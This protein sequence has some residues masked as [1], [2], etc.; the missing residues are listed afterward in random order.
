MKEL[1]AL[2]LVV[3]CGRI[4]F[5]DTDSDD[6]MSSGTANLAFVT[7]LTYPATLGG[8]AGADTMC[9]QR[10]AAAGLPGQ[11]VAWLSTS[12][13]HA[14]SRLAGSRGWRLVDGTA[15][16]DH[17]SDFATNATLA[18]LAL[19]ELGNDVRAT[20]VSVW[21]GTSTG[22]FSGQAC[23]DWTVNLAS[24]NAHV[25]TPSGGGSRFTDS[26]TPTC[27]ALAALY[28]LEIGNVAR[29]AVESRLGRYAFV[30]SV[31][32]RPNARGLASADP[33]CQFDATRAGLPGSYRALLGTS[34]QIARS[35]FDLTRG[36]WRRVDGV[37]LAA[38]AEALFTAPL[39][40]SFLARAA[41]GGV[42]SL[43]TWAGDPSVLAGRCTDW[44]VPAS[45]DTGPVGVTSLTGTAFFES[46]AGSCDRGYALVCL[47]E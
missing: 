40:D 44:T 32:W 43:E 22:Q 16:A 5:D 24:S 18:P 21:T 46:H 33:E 29:V 36:P 31:Q 3:A 8:L 30:S 47:Q 19:D 45:A 2:C 14:L 25:G 37:P 4:G 28:C 20:G 9:M 35:R 41:D 39:R 12:T 23:D 6:P 1:A 11:F 34:A 7:S 42:S 15:L 26:G 13:V 38:T 27:D 10:A 17:P